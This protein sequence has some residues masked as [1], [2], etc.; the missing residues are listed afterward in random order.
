M[1]VCS[2]CRVGLQKKMAICEPGSKQ[3]WCPDPGLPASRSKFPS[4]TIHPVYGIFVTA[5]PVDWDITPCQV[6]TDK[7]KIA[8]LV[9]LSLEGKQLDTVENK[10]D[11]FLTRPEVNL[12]Y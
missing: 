8:E 11:I 2:F 1:H 7:T 10:P 3:C 9:T 4:F 6:E 12:Q 5:A